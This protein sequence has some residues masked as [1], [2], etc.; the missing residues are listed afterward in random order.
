MAS[1]SSKQKKTKADKEVD[2]P[3]IMEDKI[4]TIVI[5][6]FSNVKYTNNYQDCILNDYINSHPKFMKKVHRLKCIQ[7]KIGSIW[8]QVFGLVPWLDDM[9]NGHVSGLDLISNKKSMEYVGENICIELKNSYNTDNASSKKSNYNKLAQYAIKNKQFQPIYAVINCNSK[10]G[11]DE[12]INH[13]ETGIN[14]RYLSGEKLLKY[15]FAD[16]YKKIMNVIKV[17]VNEYLETL[18]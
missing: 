7:M 5:T 11:K 14:I 15:I 2:N 1:K 9:K 3:T 10:N 13:K 17:Y 4:K 18:E 16:D 6:T 8:Q 12:F